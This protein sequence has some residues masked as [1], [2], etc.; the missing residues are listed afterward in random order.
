[1]KLVE[2]VYELSESFMR[3]PIFVQ[4]NE[5]GIERTAQKMI[6]DKPSPFP[7][8][9]ETPD[10][11]TV[12]L[13]ELVGGA[14]NYCY[15]YG[16]SDIRPL[17]CRSSKMFQMVSEGF[18]YFDWDNLDEVID[19][20]IHLLS[21]NRFPLLEERKVHLKELVDKNAI[22]FALKISNSD[23][24][25]CEPFLYQLVSD[26]TGYA[27]DM[28][29]KRASLFFLQLYRKL[30]WFEDSISLLH[31]P[32]DY[33]V[34]K[35]LEYEGC[36]QYS[37]G[38]KSMIGNNVPIP[39]HSNCECEIRAATILACKKLMELTKWNLSDI[40]G[41]FWLGSKKVDG[42]FHLTITTDY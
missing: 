22:D 3:E 2:N 8:Q 39:K 41:W 5:E 38:L 12:C 10:D 40:D 20:I 25:D 36:I 15:W 14:I 28:F 6:E 32:A 18:N 4:L 23:H 30:G 34:P 35:V 7:R 16:R 9:Y 24:K 1:M 19:M 27:S 31:V 21:V 26:Y 37:E 33:Q 29:L 13:L 11:T 42:P 17:D